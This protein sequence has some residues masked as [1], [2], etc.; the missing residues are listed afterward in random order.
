LGEDALRTP[1][2][3]QRAATGFE[4]CT[5]TPKK[6]NMTTPSSG[7]P[8]L[9]EESFRTPQGAQRAATGFEECTPTPKKRN[10]TTPPMCWDAPRCLQQEVEEALQQGC[11]D[12]LS[13]ALLRSHRCCA[14]HCV[15]EAVRRNFPAALDFLLE[16]G[17][18]EMDEACGGRRPLHLAVEASMRSGDSGFVM[19]ERLLARGARPKVCAGDLQDSPLHSAAKQGHAAMVAL[20]LAHGADPEQ[21]DQWGCAALHVAVQHASVFSDDGHVE[22]VKLLLRRGANP[23]LLDDSD[24]KALDYSFDTSMR[25]TLTSA[26]RRWIERVLRLA[27]GTRSPPPGLACMQVPEICAAVGNFLT[28]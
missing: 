22:A 9:G 27:F 13:I 1:Q 16:R 28:E 11:P 8:F 18:G 4:M 26:E 12:L 24:M 5:P 14:K 2:G 19:A 15:H 23:L 20:L 10:T 3:A 17:V 25:Q 7:V 21:T 6:R